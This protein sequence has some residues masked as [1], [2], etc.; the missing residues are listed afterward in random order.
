MKTTLSL[1]LSFFITHSYCQTPIDVTDQTIKIGGLEEEIPYFGFAEGDQIV[2]NFTEIERV[3][4]EILEVIFRSW[5]KI[6]NR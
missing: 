6:F 2:L 4:N 3:I 5:N 1:L